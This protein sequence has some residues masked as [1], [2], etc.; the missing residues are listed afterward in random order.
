MTPRVGIYKFIDC[1]PF[2]L[3]QRHPD[4]LFISP[5]LRV[6]PSV[7][8]F[9]PQAMVDPAMTAEQQLEWINK[10]LTFEDLDYRRGSAPRTVLEEYIQ[11][12]YDRAKDGNGNPIRTSSIRLGYTRRDRAPRLGPPPANWSPYNFYAQFRLPPDDVPGGKNA[13]PRCYRV[14]LEPKVMTVLQLDYSWM[15]WRFQP[16]NPNPAPHNPNDAEFEWEHWGELL[17]PHH[18]GLKLHVCSGGMFLLFD[19]SE[20][21]EKKTQEYRLGPSIP[22]QNIAQISGWAPCDERVRMEHY[23]VR[24]IF[25]ANAYKDPSVIQLGMNKLED[26]VCFIQFALPPW[27]P[28]YNTHFDQE[29]GS[30]P[31]ARFRYYLPLPIQDK[32]QIG[33]KSVLRFGLGSNEGFVAA[34]GFIRGPTFK[35][36]IRLHV[37]HLGAE[38]YLDKSTEG[39]PMIN[40]RLGDTRARLSAFGNIDCVHDP[41]WG[42]LFWGGK[43]MDELELPEIP[44]LVRGHRGGPPVLEEGCVVEVD[45]PSVGQRAVVVHHDGAGEEVQGQSGSRRFRRA[46]VRKT[47]AGRPASSRASSGRVGSSGAGPSSAGP[48]SRP[49]SRILDTS[50]DD[51]ESADFSPPVKH[52]RKE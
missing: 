45:V 9:L 10:K 19:N 16:G 8:A 37:C 31:P 39:F 7:T 20:G 50:S 22:R 25:Y 46:S 26:S 43:F 38:L 33:G 42:E 36:G 15:E 29:E 1:I 4:S 3:T 32:Y 47:P 30:G 24:C 11:R 23:A 44:S 52:S 21:D 6:L 49:P 13:Y 27:C 48:T 2:F 28:R 12:C 41:I 34:G 17:K 14:Y 18:V 35:I 40:H 51:S 5:R